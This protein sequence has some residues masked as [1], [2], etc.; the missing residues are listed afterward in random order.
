MARI[1][2]NMVL[3]LCLFGLQ[4][5]LLLAWIGELIE[6]KDKNWHVAGWRQRKAKAGKLAKT[7]IHSTL[8]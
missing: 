4:R 7:L 3:L 5:R 6:L 8:L 1:A 2:A